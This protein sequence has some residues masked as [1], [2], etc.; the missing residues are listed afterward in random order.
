MYAQGY[1]QYDSKKSGG[2]T[3]SHLRFGK[4]PIQSQYLV[5][6]PDFVALHK[7]SY[8]GR[9]D[10]LEGIREGGTFLINCPWPAAE[11]F[12]HLTEDMQKTIIAKK[13]KVYAIDALKV[14]K[15]L[16]LGSRINTLM[17]ACFFKI[18][19]VLPEKEAIEL[20]KKAI[21]KTFLKKGMNVVEMNWAAVDRAA[22][23]LEAVP[24]AREDHRLRPGPQAP[25]RRRRRASSR[26]SST[27]SCTSRATPSRSRRCR[28]TGRSRRPRPASRSAG[29]PRT[30]PPGS[31][32]TASSATSA[33]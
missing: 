11:V 30:S 19:G 28:S 3:I 2:V 32:R 12:E 15:E 33:P 7:I 20:I 21:K 31:P 29:S 10:I 1:F 5:D 27:R 26:T 9:Y 8:I 14:A 18:S 17:Q 24:V 23:G 4:N 25:P 6:K 22:E 16:G 13:I